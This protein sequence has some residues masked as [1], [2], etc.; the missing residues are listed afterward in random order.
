MTLGRAIDVTDHMPRSTPCPQAR[1]SPVPGSSPTTL[2][3]LPLLAVFAVAQ[4]RIISG[5]TSGAVK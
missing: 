4:R 1:R 5:I 2:M 3:S